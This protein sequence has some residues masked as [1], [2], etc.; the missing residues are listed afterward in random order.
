M[1]CSRAE[2]TSNSVDVNTLH[3]YQQVRPITTGHHRFANRK[4]QVVLMLLA[5]VC[6]PIFINTFVVFIRLYWFERRFQNVVLEARSMR[7]SRTRSV[8][9]SE[10]KP[11]LERDLG[12]E[13]NGVGDREIRVLRDAEGHVKGTKIDD[14][15]AFHEG[16]VAIVDLDDDTANSSTPKKEKEPEAEDVSSKDDRPEMVLHRN[17]TFADEVPAPNERMPQKDKETS[18]AFVENQRNPKD[19]T[20]F[21]IPGPRDY[22]LGFVPERIEEGTDLDRPRTN[23]SN[24]G[25]ALQ[26]KRSRSPSRPPPQEMNADDHPFKTHITID[27]PDVRRRS[28]AAPSAYNFNRTRRRSDVSEEEPPPS[29]FHPT[30]SRSRTFSSF[31]TRDREEADPMPYLSWTPTVGRNSAFV[32]LTEEQ[33]EELG[34]IEYRALKLLAVVLVCYFVGFHLLGMICLLPWIMNDAKYSG[35]LREVGVSPVWW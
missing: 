10:G 35:Q 2:L 20:T 33:R 6:N 28:N 30:R 21:R 9:K 17:I 11:G 26:A 31:L 5:S 12:R 13:E 4:P 22:D 16:E 32:D 27:V 18:I 14:E 19:A 8:A 23:V 25:Y 7:R 3:L 1:S 24:E 34:G 29:G 15:E